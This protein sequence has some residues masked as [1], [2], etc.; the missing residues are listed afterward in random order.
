M[1]ENVDEIASNWV[2]YT[3][4]CNPQTGDL[5]DVAP[6]D[7]DSFNDAALKLGRVMR[8]DLDESLL[9]IESMLRQSSDPWV[10]ENMGAGPLEDLLSTDDSAVLEFTGRKYRIYPNL[11]RRRGICGWIIFLHILRHLSRKYLLKTKSLYID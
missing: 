9:V 7:R 6:L 1:S 5:R 10:L 4:R 2:A 3:I 8:R 11:V